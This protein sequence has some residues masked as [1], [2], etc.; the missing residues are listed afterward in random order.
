MTRFASVSDRTAV[1]EAVQTSRVAAF[2]KYSTELKAIHASY[3]KN[4]VS[5]S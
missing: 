3:E 2:R 5:I 4:K 1:Q